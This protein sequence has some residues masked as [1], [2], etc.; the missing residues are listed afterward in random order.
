VHRNAREVELALWKYYFEN[1]SKD[2]VLSSLA[3]YQ[4]D[5]DGLGHALE[6]DSWNPD[7]SPYTT[8]RAMGILDSIGFTD[9]AHPIWKGIFRF[10]DSGAYYNEYVAVPPSRRRRLPQRDLVDIQ[11]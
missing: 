1:G 5:D 8:L 7:S 4:N 3:V 9:M 11:R 2:D 6:P 10:I